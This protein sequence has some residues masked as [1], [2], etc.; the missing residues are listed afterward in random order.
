MR[1]AT[2][3]MV[4]TLRIRQLQKDVKDAEE[5]ELLLAVCLLRLRKRKVCRLPTC[6]PLPR[7][8]FRAG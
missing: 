5:A 7:L 4:A 1:E 2:A 3:R 8:R 6:R